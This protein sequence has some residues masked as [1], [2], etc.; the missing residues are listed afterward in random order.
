MSID[1]TIDHVRPGRRAFVRARTLVAVTTVTALAGIV[2]VAPAAFGAV[3]DAPGQPAATAGNAQISLEFTPAATGDPATTF[4]ATCTSSDGGTTGTGNDTASPVV[5]TGLDNGHSYTCT[6]VAMNGEGPSVVSP[7]S[8]PVTPTAPSTVPDAPG[9]PTVAAGNAQIV[10]SFTAPADGG[11]PITGYGAT[12]TSSNGGVTQTDPGPSSPITVAPLTNGKT[13]TCIVVATN[14]I[15]SGAASPPSDPVTPAAPASV[16]GAPAAPTIVAGDSVITV[17]FSAPSS[18]G[19]SA[20]TGYTATCSASGGVTGTTSGAGSPIVVGGLTNGSS[21]TCRVFA[22]NGVGDGPASGASAAAVPNGVPGAPAQPMVAAID[23]THITVTFTAAA[24][25][26]KAITKYTVTCSDGDIDLTKSVGAVTPVSFTVI[27]GNTYTCTVFATNGNGNGPASGASNPVTP[28]VSGHVPAAPTPAPQVVAGNSQI[29]VSFFA[30]SDGGSPITG[31][32]ANCRSSLGAPGTTEGTGTT[33][34]V[35]G[36]DNGRSYTCTVFA[37]NGLG[38]GPASP[39][40]AAAVPSRRPDAPPRPSVAGGDQRITVSFSPPAF[41]G[42]KTITR[43]TATCT[44]FTTGIGVVKSITTLAPIVMTGLVNGV[45]YSCNVIAHNDNG[46]SAPSPNSLPVIPDRGPDTP[47]KPTVTAGNA[48]IKVAFHAPGDGG[49][50]IRSYGAAC[51]SSNGGRRGTKTGTTTLLIVTGLTNGKRYT[52]TV[53]ARNG[54]GVSLNSPPSVAA[55][56]TAPVTASSVSR[57]FRLFAGDGGVFTFG[58]DKSYGSAAGVAQ[59]LVVGMTTTPSEQG[60]WLVATDGGIFSFGDA[61]F[62]GSTGAIRLNQPIVGMT[63]TPSGKGYWLVASDGGI[64]SYGDAHFYG[65]TGAIRLNQPIVGMSSTPTGHGYWMVARDGGIFSFGDARFYGTP[66]G[67]AHSSVVGMATTA[68]GH[69][70]WIAAADGS[71][72]HF[73]DAT[74]LGGVTATVLRLPVRGIAS[75]RSGRGYWLATGDGGVFTFGDAP[76]IGWPGPL[77]LLASIRGVSR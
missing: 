25:N 22:S 34:V 62:Y 53:A 4:D 1:N 18:N 15:G 58:A 28:V 65:S 50:R 8:D 70:Y 2:V 33:L 69:G 23:A 67:S 31:Y 20:I 51:T 60:Y 21:Y 44:S 76:F 9:P 41:N 55:V 10:V 72:F 29:T 59:H 5:V 37:T 12:C 36:L 39:A 26:G 32:T 74:A 19:G 24:A 77:V 7:A 38:D 49:S 57:G 52:C 14:G 71:V 68:Q 17:T 27:T 63:T 54:R 43:Y 46:D 30:P 35:L 42:G 47:A 45:T 56:P 3:P 75:T 6:V 66:V 61:H 16:P 73:G 48:Q 64:F 40:S 11:S 13:Y